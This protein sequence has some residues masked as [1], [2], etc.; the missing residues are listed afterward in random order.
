MAS[1]KKTMQRIEELQS[2]D[3]ETRK[4]AARWLGK[5]ATA[6]ALDPLLAALQDSSWKVRRNAA[7][8]LGMLKSPEAVEPLLAALS[9]RTLSVQREAVNSLGKIQDARAIEPLA[10][11]SAHPKLG[12]DAVLALIGIGAP[13]LL[14]YSRLLQTASPPVREQ[15]QSV[16]TQ[17]LRRSADSLLKAALRL[18]GWSGQQRWLVLETT[19][20]TQES[21]AFFE[22]WSLSKFSRITNIAA[23]CSRIV[24]APEHA[25]L[26]AGVRQVQDYLM[27]GRASQRDHASE[28]AELLRGAAGTHRQ[29]TGETLL[30]ASEE[31]A[32][33]PARPSLL[34]RLRRWFGKKG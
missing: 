5:R 13:A 11:L 1:R 3:I 20:R 30:R 32:E 18:E 15:A 4:D 21:F 9:D 31:S 34:D 24:Q 17:M 8:S 23:W 6:E 12:S 33:T 10:A 16:V 7:F 25:D 2:E 26:H 19:R 14:H 28:S 22:Q 29:D 27:L